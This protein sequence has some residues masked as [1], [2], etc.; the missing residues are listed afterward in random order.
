LSLPAEH[1]NRPTEQRIVGELPQELRV[2]RFEWK[3][4]A[5]LLERLLARGAK[6]DAAVRLLPGG[7]TRH[8]VLDLEEPHEEAPVEPAR[9]VAGMHRRVAQRERAA[10]AEGRFDHRSDHTEA[11][12]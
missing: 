4:E 10:G 12:G 1:A 9:R 7:G 2:V 8:T 6:L 5:Q 11:S 3:D